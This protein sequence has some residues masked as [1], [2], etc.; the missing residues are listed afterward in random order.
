MAQEKKKRRYFITGLLIVLPVL[1]TLYLFI[2]LFNFFDNILGRY[3]SR[4]TMEAFGYKI[5][6]LGILL[7][8][9]VIF[10]TGFFATN[11]IGRKFLL[12][13]ENLWLRFPVVKKVYPAIKQIT[14]FLFKQKAEGHFQKVVLVQYPRQGLYVVGFVTNQADKEIQEKTNKDLLN[15]LVPT[16]PNPLSGFVIHVPRA[17]VIY[18]DMTVEQAI[19]IIVSGGVLNPSDAVDPNSNAYLD[20]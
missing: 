2:S 18:L 12:Y 5:P 16:V 14:H 11:F 1:A 15:V 7:F 6:G 3:I 9:I 4:L 20:E 10:T 8:I 13:L 19:K 17:D